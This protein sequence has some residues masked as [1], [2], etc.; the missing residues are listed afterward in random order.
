MLDPLVTPIPTL[1]GRQVLLRALAPED[2]VALARVGLDPRIWEWTGA[3]VTDL[4]GMQRYVDAALEERT[5]GAAQPFAILDRA[6]GDVIGTTRFGS[7]AFEHRRVEIGWTWLGAQF[8]RTGR[9]VE[10]KLLLLEFAFE[11]LELRRVE[12]KTDALNVRSRTA[13]EALGATFEGVF[14]KH[15]VRPDGSARDSAYY[16]IVDDQ[17]PEVRA[18]LE[19]RLRPR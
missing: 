7:P 17:W 2:A 15:M 9:N 12:F 8:W 10:A 5:R 16:A 6:S 14:A 13:I 1:E 11:Q 3:P 4:A 18:G 19:A